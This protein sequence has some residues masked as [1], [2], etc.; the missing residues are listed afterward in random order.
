MS[1]GSD[2]DTVSYSR[3]LTSVGVTL[4]GVA[5][6]GAPGENDQAGVP[7]A[8]S[9]ASD[10]E[11]VDGGDGSDVLIGS[12]GPNFLVSRGGPDTIT[13]LGGADTIDVLDR[14][15]DDHVDAGGGQD[16]CAADVADSL[17]TCEQI[18]SGN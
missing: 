3:R 14:V 13:G 12:S 17:T 1:G 5:N 10:V 16:Y 18:F 8:P 11:N 4:D 2:S 9:G 15:G 6:D 7:Q